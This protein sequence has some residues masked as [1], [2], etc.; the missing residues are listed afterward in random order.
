VLRLIPAIVIACI[1]P[2][3][4][5]QGT[6]ADTT[7]EASA[8]RPVAGKVSLVEGDVRFYDKNQQLRRPN[9]GDAIYEG[10]GIF[11]GKDGEVHFDMEDGGY[12]GVRPGTKMRVI[13][14][15]AEGGE[16]DQSVIGLLEGSFRSIT[17]WIGKLRG[18]HYQIST[19]TATIGVRGTE[20]EPHVIPEGSADGEPGTY[21]RVHNGETVM[22]TSQGTVNVRANQAGFM[23]LRGQSRPRLLDRIPVFFRP[24]R[25]EARFQGLHLRVQQRMEQRR[26]QRVQQ[27]QERRKKPG[28]LREQRQQP[29][30]QQDPQSRL[31]VQ[32]QVQEQ[33]GVRQQQERRRQQEKSQPS[34]AEKQ[35]GILERQRERRQAREAAPKERKQ[36]LEER[37][38]AE[39]GKRGRPHARE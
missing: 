8:E 26:Q 5:G 31:Q 24:T 17:G 20:H 23:P 38:K 9:L 25:N 36:E 11:T 13:S 4:L 10:D 1:S 2:L 39:R 7:A 3:A 15:K 22:Q 35:S 21:D 34:R 30:A 18:N 14:Y 16:D 6:A 28:A 19:P 32:K 37:R 27:I 29:R 33:R 12:I